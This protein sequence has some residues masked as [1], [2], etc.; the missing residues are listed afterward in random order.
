MSTITIDGRS[1]LVLIDLQNGIL[2]LPTLV[3]PDGVTPESTVA[4]DRAK[5]DATQAD[6]RAA[7]ADVAPGWCRGGAGSQ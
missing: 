3:G 7:Q 2:A 6:S 5:T 1:A 4:L